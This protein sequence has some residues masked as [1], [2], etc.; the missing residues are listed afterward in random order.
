VTA[1]E[2]LT[3]FERGYGDDPDM[4][5]DPTV[6]EPVEGQP[7][8]THY[9]IARRTITDEE[10]RCQG[11]VSVPRG[12]GQTTKVCNKFLARRAGRPWEIPCPRCGQLNTSPESPE[13]PESP[14]GVPGS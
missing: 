8:L 2:A 5:L 13:V 1:Q 4:E 12:R 11:V 9:Q 3:A 6:H 7:Q 10:I 14:K